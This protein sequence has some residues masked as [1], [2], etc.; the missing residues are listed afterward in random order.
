[1][2]IISRK[3]LRDF[4]AKHPAARAELEAWYAEAKGATWTTPAEV[5]AKY[6]TASIL[7]HGRVAFNI[8]GTKYRLVVWI[9]YDYGVVY[10]RFL[11]THKEYDKIDAERV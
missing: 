6:R 3:P 7:K 11:G 1:M 10:I 9:N 5:K 4:A 8:C 2:R